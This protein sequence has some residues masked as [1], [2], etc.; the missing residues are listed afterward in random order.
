M[1]D[2]S[3]SRLFCLPDSP[4]GPLCGEST[5]PNNP[6]RPQKPDDRPQMA[7]TGG[8]QGIAFGSSQMVRRDVGSGF[9]EERQRAVVQDVMVLEERVRIPKSGCK[10]TPEPSP[11][12]LG[13]SALETFDRPL[14]MLCSRDFDGVGQPQP[15]PN[16]CDLPKWDSGL[17]HS[18]GSRIHS[19]EDHALGTHPKSFLIRHVD[20]PRVVQ[21]A[22][23]PV[24]GRPK[25]PGT[26]LPAQS[27]SG[28]DQFGHQSEA[29]TLQDWVFVG[30]FAS[31]LARAPRHV[32]VQFE[33][34]LL[35]FSPNIPIFLQ[36][37][38]DN[39]AV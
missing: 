7:I 9:G 11:T 27:L 15:V 25:H 24:N 5:D 26:C 21:G 10:Q 8:L 13:S 32:A 30:K 33:D 2:L 14:R 1:E 12:D 20:S 37:K 31:P 22:V 23:D 6:L 4:A 28:C 35:R 39:P 17:N 18:K 19:D 29:A 36:S 34:K 16:R 38:S 3:H